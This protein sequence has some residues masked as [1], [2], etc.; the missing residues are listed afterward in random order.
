MPP[1]YLRKTSLTR[2]KHCQE[3]TFETCDSVPTDNCCG[4]IPCTFCLEWEVYG[5]TINYGS[6]EFGG[7]SWAGTVGGGSFVAYWERNYM[8]DECEFIVVFDDEEVYRASCYTGASC[9]NPGGEVTATLAYQEGTLRWSVF[10]PRELELIDNPDTGCKDFFCGTCRCSCECLLVTITTIGTVYSG[11]ICDVSYSDCD[12]PIW[13]GSVAGYVLSVE[14][15]RD[16]YTGNCTVTLTA[17]GETPEPVFATGCDDMTA[18][19]TLLDGTVVAVECKRCRSITGCPNGCCPGSNISDITF[20]N[21][22][23]GPGSLGCPE[24]PLRTETPCV[25]G[26]SMATCI[27][28]EELSFVVGPDVC[29]TFCGN[30]M[31]LGGS[32]GSYTFDAVLVCGETGGTGSAFIK[33]TGT[34]P[35]GLSSDVWIETEG[36]FNC[37]DCSAEYS[38]T[39]QTVEMYFD[40]YVNCGICDA[41]KIVYEEDGSTTCVPDS[42][43][44]IRLYF[45]AVVACD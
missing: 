7:S 16:L 1:R 5:E 35:P 26:F 25:D 12:A 17:D 27:V 44:S 34:A 8:T 30:G 4:V 23:C 11:E 19:V 32:L 13:E 9:R 38:G 28:P 18:S 22:A 43:Y 24:M 31:T 29:N 45:S 10:R 3:R 15:G 37:P 42:L 39:E 36:G 40:A 2:L 33:Y 20:F 21:S 6:A 41:T 14:L